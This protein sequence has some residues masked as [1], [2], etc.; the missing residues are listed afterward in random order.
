M[1]GVHCAQRDI[2]DKQ[3]KRMITFGST[4]AYP[5]KRAEYDSAMA[6]ESVGSCTMER[7]RHLRW[8]LKKNQIPWKKMEGCW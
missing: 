2:V 4:I 3:T 5:W 8:R 1:I 6:E 7:H